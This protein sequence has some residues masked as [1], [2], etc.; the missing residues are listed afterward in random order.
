MGGTTASDNTLVMQKS[1]GSYWLS[2]WNES[3][4]AHNVTLTLPAAAQIKVFDP[5]TGTGGVNGR[6]PP[7]KTASVSD[8]PVIVEI[9]APWR[10]YRPVP[11]SR[12]ARS[13]VCLDR[14]GGGRGE[15]R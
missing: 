3:D 15:G 8:H 9:S 2:L 10:R 4:A 5:L 14:G 12:S 7:R 13:A 6:Q 11:S 1:D